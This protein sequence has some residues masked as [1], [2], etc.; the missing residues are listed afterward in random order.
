MNKIIVVT[1]TRKG[2]G[3]QIANYFLENGCFVYGCSRRH[4]SIEHENYSHYVMDVSS[5]E[6]VINLVRSVYKER[7][8]I[9]FLIN[10]AG[11]ASM[12]HFILTP[13][14][15]A[16]KLINTNFMGTF[17]LCREVSKFMI[18]QKYGRIINFTTV[19]V[20]LNL[21]GELVYSASKSAVEQLTRVLANEIGTL[22]VTVNAIGPTPIETDLIKNVPK[23]KIQELI[24]RQ[25][26]ERLGEFK[27]VL[28]IIKFFISDDSDFVTGQIIYL[29]GVN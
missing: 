1:G 20:P 28:N 13:Y 3:L 18:K 22:G 2:L 14:E 23:N 6:D 11:A 17:L 16:K 25:S 5:E 9:D 4:S 15:T 8:R 26:I 10:N 27:D 29:G 7:G 24:S 21:D 19:A 12:N